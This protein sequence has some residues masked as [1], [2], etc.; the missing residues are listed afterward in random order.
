MSERKSDESRLAAA[1]A[2]ADAGDEEAAEREFLALLAAHRESGSI[3]ERLACSS[4]VTLF[5]RQRRHFEVITLAR[6]L[7]A[8]GESA[9]GGE[10]SIAYAAFA[11]AHAWID[12]HVH[13]DAVRELDRLDA[14]LPGLSPERRDL[15]ER[16]AVLLR[17]RVAIGNEDATDAMKWHARFVELAAS[18]DE[19]E[20][21][22]KM[23]IEIRSAQI[24][25]LQGAV[26][27]GLAC[28]AEAESMS[29][30]TSDLVEIRITTID[31][32]KNGG[33]D[34]ELRA[35]SE[36]FIRELA[37]S[38]DELPYASQSAWDGARTILEALHDRPDTEALVFQSW[39]I[40]STALLRRLQELRRAANRLPELL[41]THE[42]DLERFSAV[43]DASNRW[44]DEQRSR[45]RPLLHKVQATVAQP[46][47]AGGL[48]VICAWCDSIDVGDGGWLPLLDR[49]HAIGPALASHGICPS[50]SAQ[51]SVE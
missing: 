15:L 12:L 3:T 44:R 33:G 16:M 49:L 8:L 31:L 9:D 38:L 29:P 1:R 20:S 24:H 19:R 6:R 45:L 10:D 22:D 21:H 35:C 51:L 25:A 43:R 5:G 11:R 39:E 32:L 4:L 17:T 23:A 14:A 40:L 28:L 34:D 41:V 42:D 46:P 2:A 7:R 26:D 36:T 47:A 13:D 18:D 30:D 48:F 50:C 37:A 27:E